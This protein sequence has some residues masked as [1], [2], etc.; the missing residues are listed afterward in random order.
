MKQ[1][2][3]DILYW[4]IN[5]LFTTRFK[6]LLLSILPRKIKSKVKNAI[7]KGNVH[8][9]YRKIDLLRYKLNNLGFTEQAYKELLLAYE[10]SHDK[11]FK[12][13]IALELAVWHAN[14]Q[15]K[16]DAR[17]CIDYLQRVK[18]GLVDKEFKKQI[19]ILEVESFLLLG[20]EKT[21]ISLLNKMLKSYTHPDL[22][23][24]NANTKTDL[25]IRINEINQAMAYYNIAP[26]TLKEMNTEQA[27]Y[28]LLK[29]EKSNLK[30]IEDKLKVTV[31]MPVYNAEDVIHT[32]ITSIQNQTWENLEIIVVDDCSSDRTAEIIE[33]YQESDARIKFLKLTENSGPYVARNEALNIAT[34]EFVT[35]NDADDWSHP[36]KIEKQ[37]QHLVKNPKIIGN[38]SQQA[39]ASDNLFFNR[40]GKLGTYIFSNMSSF[41]FRRE[42]V[43]GKLGYWDSVRFGADSEFIKRIKKVFGENSIV[44][45][46]SGPLSFQ[47]YSSNSLTGNSAFG[48]PN[49]FMGA[50]KEYLEAQTQH[51][52]ATEDLKYNYPLVKRPFAIPE[53]MRPVREI[54]NKKQRHFDVII[55]SDFRL[56]GGSTKSS[57]EEIKAQLEVG[58]KT[59]IVQI[60]RYDYSP[61][62]KINPEVRELINSGMVELIV[63]GEHVTCDL[64]ILRY[65]P[66]LQVNQ[67][68][69]PDI[70]PN[71]IVAIINQTPMSDYS[72]NKEKRY[73][74]PV[75]NQRIKDY[76]GKKAKWY[77]I[78]P[79]VRNA[80]IEYH[81]EDL[82]TIELSDTDWSNIIDV[83][84]W[85]NSSP[86]TPSINSP[87]IIGRHSRGQ[88]VKWPESREALIQVYP[89]TPKYK[90][91]VLGGASVPKEMLGELPDNWVVYEFD[92]ISPKEF[93]DKIDVFVYY[94]HSA[95][96]ESFGR[97]IIEAM[98]CGK[99]V[100]LPPQYNILFG[101]AAIY[102]TPSNL[103]QEL[104]NLIS[105]PKYYNEQVKKAEKLIENNFSYKTHINRVKE[106]IV[107]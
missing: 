59:A 45:L 72:D 18:K 5:N 33:K 92:E 4:T 101:D 91:Y 62:K 80:L 16:E 43:L 26:V 93:L 9:A 97:V 67:K 3:S 17:K 63:Y 104:D 65:P 10:E 39:R 70:M 27:P 56:D 48:F 78:G 22:Y 79:L 34:G 7:S 42:K 58:L 84:E 66:I 96:I 74:I 29:V 76:F 105:N 83:N 61:K 77:P 44:L 57:I 1:Y 81:I 51:H 68:Y 100:I 82:K 49:F 88:K 11:H 107:D 46:E 19:V 21:A 71:K 40:R 36:E 47:R 90:V 23:L 8:K 85:R 38:T 28:D 69:I 53:P 55:G 95:W 20:E 106:F 89:N 94:T 50:R 37:V 54:D 6:K 13:T 41:M 75:C 24:T 30:M 60:A 14:Q 73:D 15:T 87:I 31:I 35:I 25:S 98:A 2:L 99:P 102:S 86:D 12:R 64:L 32:S 103:Q 52:N